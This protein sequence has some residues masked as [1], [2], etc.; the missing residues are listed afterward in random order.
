MVLQSKSSVFI[1]L[2]KAMFV[3]EDGCVRK[4]WGLRVERKGKDRGR[5]PGPLNQTD[6]GGH[7]RPEVGE[8]ESTLTIGPFM[9]QH[10][11]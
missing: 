8:G 3:I 2:Q 6:T 5:N 1:P 9:I 7:G 11:G 4:K 10:P